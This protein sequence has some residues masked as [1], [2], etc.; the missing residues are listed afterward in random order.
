MTFCTTGVDKS[1][2]SCI[3][4]DQKRDDKASFVKPAQKLYPKA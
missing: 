2:G 4:K 3:M 1:D